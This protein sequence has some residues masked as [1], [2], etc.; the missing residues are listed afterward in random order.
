MSFPGLK[1]IFAL[2]VIGWQTAQASPYVK[3][4]SRRL[5]RA[6]A[7]GY[8]SATVDIHP[9][10]CSG[11]IEVINGEEEDIAEVKVTYKVG[12]SSSYQSMHVPYIPAK[13]A[14]RVFL[15]HGSYTFETLSIGRTTETI[16]IGRTT[17]SFDFDA[18]AIR[19][20]L[21]TRRDFQIGPGGFT[22]GNGRPLTPGELLGL[23]E[24]NRALDL[25]H[26]VLL[27]TETGREQLIQRVAKEP[28]ASQV[29]ALARR[30]GPTS[31]AARSLVQQAL[32]YPGGVDLTGPLS[33]LLRQQ[34]NPRSP[35]AATHTSSLWATAK[36]ANLLV[37]VCPPSE[38][39][40]AAL[41]ERATNDEISAQLGVL[42]FPYFLAA[43]TSKKT[44]E[45][46]L[47]GVLT[48]T[49]DAGKL[50]TIVDGQCHPL[51]PEAITRALLAGS[52]PLAAER[53][54]LL[55][56]WLARVAGDAGA[57]EKVVLA[58]ARVLIKGQDLDKQAVTEIAPHINWSHPETETLLRGELRSGF[59][60]GAGVAEA[61]PGSPKDLFEVLRF[62][63][64]LVPGC[65]AGA[66][67]VAACSLHLDERPDLAR[68]GLSP[69]RVEVI[70]RWAASRLFSLPDPALEQV[71]AR[72]QP[73][74][75]SRVHAIELA[76]DEPK[77]DLKAFDTVDPGRICQSRRERQA[78]I[79]AATGIAMKTPVLLPAVAAFCI[80]Y[81]YLRRKWRT[82]APVLREGMSPEL[83]S[84]SDRLAD[85]WARTFEKCLVRAHGNMAGA[86]VPGCETAAAALE[87]LLPFHQTIAELTISTATDAISSGEA[88]S[89]L[90]RTGGGV[91]YVLVFPSEHSD[92][93]GVRRHQ[94]F[95]LGW[96]A[97][98][99]AIRRRIQ[100]GE[101]PAV[102]L[103]A[104]F[105]HPEARRGSMVV[106]YD[107]GH[108]HVTP[109]VL[110]EARAQRE[111]SGGLSF[112]RTHFELSAET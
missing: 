67:D 61:F 29:L 84:Y 69:A 91:A 48:T 41:V 66:P 86:G 103:L 12:F 93:R 44:S 87:K 89:S 43:C 81:L 27:E 63:W 15:G 36:A 79:A 5:P 85:G 97:H 24:G 78:L 106:G 68:Y 102:L 99:K 82:L 65:G 33:P 16:S 35:G 7:D 94:G 110:L 72:L 2:A 13:T 34:C 73:W 25:A 50:R 62:S 26:Q 6:K 88:Q 30:L 21:R 39:D 56:G 90:V 71:L 96:E 70:E 100:S 18:D 101:L 22:P 14:A 9:P 108:L 20:L 74:G 76:C 19:R 52:A 42:P 112:E 47:A 57:R 83:P 31:Q 3:V 92:G 53:R 46:I 38:S 49:K 1:T 32:N 80:L 75:V 64:S 11:C 23:V 109:A 107:D 54:A 51:A 95:T 55:Q 77:L 8:G 98:A 60:L 111:H 58:I 40:L 45:D 59:M 10:G 37:A 17:E 104:F 4:D 105:L 28:R